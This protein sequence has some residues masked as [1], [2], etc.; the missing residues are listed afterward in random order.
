M[1]RITK[2]KFSQK[3][4]PVFVLSMLEKTVK[5]YGTPFTNKDFKGLS[6]QHA[7]FLGIQLIHKTLTQTWTFF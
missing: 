5:Q 4:C 7:Q 3:A 6:M 2:K 1:P